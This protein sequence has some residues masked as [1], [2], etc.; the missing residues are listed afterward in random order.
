M[1]FERSPIQR[2][3]RSCSALADA[4][5]LIADG[6][7]RYETALEYRRVAARKMESARRPYDYVMMTLLRS[8]I[9]VSDSADASI[10]PSLAGRRSNHWKR[11]RPKFDLREVHRSCVRAAISEQALERSARPQGPRSAA[12]PTAARSRRDCHGDARCRPR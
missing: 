8:T 5:V 1:R 9:P 6:H 4:R 11:A 2:R 10:G 12:S 3:L 7:H